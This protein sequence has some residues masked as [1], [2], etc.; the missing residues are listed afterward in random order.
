MP[1]IVGN[2]HKG[3][4]TGRRRNLTYR[5]PQLSWCCFKGCYFHTCIETENPNESVLVSKILKRRMLLL[6]IN[7]KNKQI[8]NYEL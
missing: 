3:V 1:V 6:L 4:P 2:H 8:V 7:T 5:N